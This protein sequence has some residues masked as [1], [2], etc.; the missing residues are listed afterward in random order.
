MSEEAKLRLLV[1]VF[2]VLV[3]T[4]LFTFSAFYYNPIAA[5]IAVVLFSILWLTFFKYLD[6]LK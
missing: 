2:L 3:F 4:V 1:I 6:K 5:P